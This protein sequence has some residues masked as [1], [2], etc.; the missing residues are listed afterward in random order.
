MF[1][2]RKRNDKTFSILPGFKKNSLKLVVRI[3]QNNYTPFEK[4]PIAIVD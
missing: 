3:K 2:M 1:Y 4:Q